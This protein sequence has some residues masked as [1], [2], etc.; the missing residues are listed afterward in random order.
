[1][2]IEISLEQYNDMAERLAELECRLG[3]AEQ[4]WI[5][6]SERL[7]SDGGCVLV[8]IDDRIEFGMCEDGEWS[9]WDCEH[10][11]KWGSKGTI[12]WMPLPK[13]YKGGDD[14]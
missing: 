9:I 1:M 5:P 11:D 10:W 13:P 14:E 3:E 12:A 6:C 2:M 8:S 4:R 7:P